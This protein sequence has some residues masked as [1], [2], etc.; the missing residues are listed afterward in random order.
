[1]FGVAGQ[2]K[3]GK[4]RPTPGEEALSNEFIEKARNE[5][6]QSNVKYDI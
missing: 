5:E 6:E 1:V 3:F 4:C 2:L